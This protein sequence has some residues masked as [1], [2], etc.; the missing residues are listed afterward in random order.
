MPTSTTPTFGSLPSPSSLPSSSSL[1]LPTSTGAC[2]GT[3]VGT[4]MGA[5]DSAAAKTT[6]TLS[7]A[8]SMPPTTS[9]PDDHHSSPIPTSNASFLQQQL[10]PS[11]DKLHSYDHSRNYSTSTVGSGSTEAII[12]SYYRN[13]G[14][15]F[16]TNDGRRS[17][18]RTSSY[19]A[20][21]SLGRPGST[22]ITSSMP[23]EN[24]RVEMERGVLK[25]QANGQES[26]SQ[27]RSHAAV[28]ESDDD[29]GSSD[30]PYSSLVAASKLLPPTPTATSTPVITT[31]SADAE[32]E[33]NEENQDISKSKRN[34]GVASALQALQKWFPRSTSLNGSLP[35][36]AASTAN[37]GPAT[38]SS[39]TGANADTALRDADSSSDI[40]HAGKG[41]EDA[42][43]QR[44]NRHL[45]FIPTSDESITVITPPKSPAAQQGQPSLTVSPL[46]TA[47]TISSSPAPNSY[48]PSPP[49]S[50]KSPTVSQVSA[51]FISI[52]LPNGSQRRSTS[53]PNTGTSP[54]AIAT[55][56]PSPCSLV[57]QELQN[58]AAV[59]RMS[60]DVDGIDPDLHAFTSFE[61]IPTLA[62]TKSRRGRKNSRGRIDENGDIIASAEGSDSEDDDGDTA[63]LYWVPAAVHP[64]LAPNAFRNFL[65]GRVEA[66]KRRREENEA[67][68]R[69]VSNASMVSVASSRSTGSNASGKSDTLVAGNRGGLQRRKSLLSRQVE[70]SPGP[71]HGLSR[72]GNGM[73]SLAED[74]ELEREGSSNNDNN[75]QDDAGGKDSPI[76]STTIAASTNPNVAAANA[77]AM[78]IGLDDDRP[79]LPPQPPTA[80]FSL[81]R[82]TRTNYRKGSMST[83]NRGQ[84]SRARGTRQ[85]GMT[86]RAEDINTSSTSG[87]VIALDSIS[88]GDSPVHLHN[89]V[90]RVGPHGS[91]ITE[92]HQQQIQLQHRS[93]LESLAL[94]MT[95]SMS[96]EPP[97]LQQQAG[98]PSMSAQT[99]PGLQTLQVYAPAS[100]VTVQ[101]LQQPDQPEAQL[102]NQTSAQ[103]QTQFPTEPP[104]RST[105]ASS[106]KKS[107]SS[108][109]H[110]HLHD[111]GHDD[112]HSESRSTDGAVKPP[113]P[114]LAPAPPPTPPQSKKRP[115][116]MRSKDGSR[117][118]SL[119]HL[120]A[121][122]VTPSSPSSPPP[123]NSTTATVTSTPTQR[124][125]KKEGTWKSSWG[126][127]RG[128]SGGVVDDKETKKK[129]KLREKEAK[130][131]ANTQT[132]A[133]PH[134]WG[135]GHGYHRKVSGEEENEEEVLHGDGVKKRE[136]VVIDRTD[137]KLDD[138]D[139]QVTNSNASGSSS[140]HSLT[141]SVSIGFGK[142]KS[143]DKDA[144]GSGLFSSLFGSGK[145]KSS[146]SGGGS[147][148]SGHSSGR[149][150]A[151]FSHKKLG[152]RAGATSP[153]N[154]HRRV[155]GSA[156]TATNN[157]G[158]KRSGEVG[159]DT[160][161]NVSGGK[162]DV[163]VFV[164]RPDIDYPWTRFTLAEEREIYRLAHK[165]LSCQGR[166]LLP[167]VLL[168]N[169]MYSYL[170]KVQ[171]A[172]PH[173]AL[174][175]SAAQNSAMKRSQQE[176][177][178]QQEALIRQQ[179][180]Q[181]QAAALAAT[182][183]AGGDA[184]RQYL[185]G[186]AGA[187]ADA[188]QMQVQ[189]H[190]SQWAETDPAKYEEFERQALKQWEDEQT[191]QQVNGTGMVGIGPVGVVNDAGQAMTW[192]D[193]YAYEDAYYGYP[194]GR[195]STEE[196]KGDAADAGSASG[197]V[198]SAGG[199]GDN[200][201]APMTMN[202]SNNAHSQR[203]Q[204]LYVRTSSNG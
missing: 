65:S 22:L 101:P 64:E 41:Q 40:Y 199:A 54:P 43:E 123:E 143:K 35:A 166:P 57:A 11:F 78:V 172:N 137:V 75:K 190:I 100:D 121:S 170:A 119:S 176:Q 109:L 21:Y 153:E 53:P 102:Q 46:A 44:S 118:A 5:T 120:P 111:K 122:G 203:Q 51:S 128:N 189:A 183:A 81:R 47:S 89:Q 13:S 98:Q 147:S 160:A 115:P 187:V 177:A 178:A 7:T 142:R 168:S 82:S 76:I 180:E 26:E 19:T 63:R 144:G 91:E 31:T 155:R 131:H 135:H 39:S 16:D 196:G 68:T 173:M 145:R 116:L 191:E 162:H 169:F 67:L 201:S 55:T 171:A 202:T 167:Q 108:F 186:D 50:T 38:G 104:L 95:R 71:G 23:E 4:N 70:P 27:Y 156:A 49:L 72:S 182:A 99:Q 30:F 87:D 138:D 112:S 52:C 32:D 152:S 133:H 86:S 125:E 164:L 129:E 114:P 194:D 193:I 197:G 106:G 79:I 10:H 56:C 62:P 80:A 6:S 17:S 9:I 146:S 93:S 132:P 92:Q 60:L 24:E 84:P 77:V 110:S 158:N 83:G 8:L 200:G 20:R 136:S 14:E 154:G 2:L 36:A 25:E 3:G 130:S 159:A 42:D 134:G 179:Q 34:E 181:H 157:A 74:G 204:Q 73:D 117:S 163:D 29:S 127:L 96:P 185:A 61:S 140:H 192:E 161:S 139:T 175:T 45:S 33:R 124:S 1:R 174:P 151:S 198:N 28:D 107:A 85:R 148:D 12:G 103:A 150:I 184:A 88:S 126:W 66:M 149:G 188:Y 141:G 165:K 97:H 113:T 48:S 59:R 58:I 94:S 195:N 69:S 90:Q 105:S 15:D 37:A 18:D